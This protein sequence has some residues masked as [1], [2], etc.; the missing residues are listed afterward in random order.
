MNTNNNSEQDF[1]I[2]SDNL[3]EN[4]VY[5]DK[6]NDTENDVYHDKENYKEN[7]IKTT[8]NEPQTN[9]LTWYNRIFNRNKNLSP[10]RITSIDQ[11]MEG[12]N[13]IFRI[14]HKL[15][16]TNFKYAV[17]LI[18]NMDRE[19]EIIKAI[20][21]GYTNSPDK[22]GQYKLEVET[23]KDDDCKVKTYN[24]LFYT[25]KFNNEE[26]DSQIRL[27]EIEKTNENL[28][29]YNIKPSDDITYF[30]KTN[31]LEIEKTYFIASD[32]YFD[33]DQCWILINQPLINN[34][35]FKV[36]DIYIYDNPEFDK[37]IVVLITKYLSIRDNTNNNTYTNYIEGIFL[38]FTQNKET[39]IKLEFDFDLGFTND[40]NPPLKVDKF[41]NENSEN[42]SNEIEKYNLTAKEIIPNNKITDKYGY[43][44]NEN[45]VR[46][47][48]IIK[49]F[50]NKINKTN[51]ARPNNP[52][53]YIFPIV[54][55]KDGI[56]YIV[57]FKVGFKNTH[58]ELNKW[59][60]LC[61]KN[62]FD[63]DSVYHSDTRIP[64]AYNERLKK[65]Q[66]ERL[67]KYRIKNQSSDNS[68]YDKSDNLRGTLQQNAA[69]TGA[70]LAS[71]NA[72]FD[73]SNL[74]FGGVRKRTRKH[75]ITR[76]PH[77]KHRKHK[78][79]RKPYK[80]IKPNKHIKTKKN[81]NKKLQI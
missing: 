55:E 17:F 12:H 60:K 74:L 21:L 52:Y 33:K 3:K 53:G 38:G 54:L 50:T 65:E 49:K 46:N 10:S 59:T 32:I 25:D 73:L 2:A 69:I 37:K 48:Y 15:Y 13:Y 80:N 35:N 41:L 58:E 4:D 51:I 5:H 61:G 77:N 27:Y 75:K 71:N 30:K 6:E 23:D 72:S 19:K 26:K 63:I 16:Y 11:F 34:I 64:K 40:K 39:P 78:I 31:E 62:L 44:I 28:K 42:Y 18:K 76:K 79:T 47:N 1:G 20:F 22:N 66:E 68:V 56:Q 29:K 67:K 14:K 9:N 57:E 81:K 7:D 36:D 8:I 24:V 43:H 45:I 70:T